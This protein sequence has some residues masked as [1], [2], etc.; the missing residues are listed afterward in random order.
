M[1]LAQMKYLIAALEAKGWNDE[2]IMIDSLVSAAEH[3]IIYFGFPPDI[4]DK[5]EKKDLEKNTDIFIDEEFDCF[6]KYV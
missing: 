2:D 4:F 5:K 1:K 6:M 3:D